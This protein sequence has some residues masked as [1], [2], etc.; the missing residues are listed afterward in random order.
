MLFE[1]IQPDGKTAELRRQL[2][3]ILDC[4]IGDDQPGQASLAQVSG[5]QFDGLTRAD[6]QGGL[7]VQFTKYLARELTAPMTIRQA[8]NVLYARG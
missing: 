2:L 3:R 5:D 1:G 8:K 4:A 7:F 6:Q